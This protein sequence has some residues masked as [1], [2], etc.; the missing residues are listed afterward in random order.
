MEKFLWFYPMS[1][2]S[3]TRFNKESDLVLLEEGSIFS[4]ISI[5]FLCMFVLCLLLTEGNI[6][7]QWFLFPAFKNVKK[8]EDYLNSFMLNSLQNLPK[9]QHHLGFHSFHVSSTNA[10]QPKVINGLHLE[11]E[12]FLKNKMLYLCPV[13]W[14]FK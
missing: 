4:F 9:F 1:S 11:M 8:I 6:F 10:G 12:L 7:N 13:T 14:S 3:F 2:K 5:F